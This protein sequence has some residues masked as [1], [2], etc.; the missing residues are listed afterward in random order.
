MTFKDLHRPG[1]PLLLPNAWD[2][3]SAAALAAAG[4][5]ALGT[6]SLGVAAAA[7][8]PDGAGD[9][10]EET[11]ALVRLIAH[12][13]A[14][15]TVDLEDGYS[16]D[17]GAVADLA[18]RLHELGAA[19]VNLEDQLRDGLEAKVAAVKARVPDLFVNARTDTHWLKR[20]QKTTVARL[21]RYVDAGADGVFAPGLTDDSAIAALADAVDAPLNVLASHPLSRL[22]ELGVARVSTGSG[23]FRLAL[24]AATDAATAFRD[25]GPPPTGGPSYDEIQGLTRA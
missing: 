17:P 2:H 25:G 11:V 14:F 23:L 24:G 16:D 21:S 12:L 8:K 1:D 6:T 9:T 7:G 18:V 20:E 10:L 4:F 3:A 22:A 15:I 5:P 13:D 19:G